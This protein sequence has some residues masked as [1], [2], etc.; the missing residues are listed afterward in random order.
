MNIYTDGSCAPSNPGPGGWGA[1]AIDGDKRKK[2]WGAEGWT[3]NNRMEVLAAIRG[4]EAVEPGGA[5]TVHSDSQ[6]L[7]NT[8]TKSWKKN[9]NQDLWAQV[10]ALCAE[11]RVSWK[12]VRGHSGH[13]ENEEA[14]RL[15]N[16]ARE[17]Y[18][19]DR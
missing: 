3:T 16:S 11:R 4:L 5:V 6:Y 10:D 15:A 17:A 13:P 12:W 2:L 1:I 14:D 18:L 9:K 7:V 19:S 8:M